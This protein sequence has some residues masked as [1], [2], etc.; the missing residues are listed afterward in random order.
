M[1]KA[2]VEAFLAEGASV[3]TCDINKEL[4]AD[5]KEN[6]ATHH[7]DR[8]LILEANLTDD[9]AQDDLFKQAIEKY[10]QVDFVVNSAG[11]MDDFAPAGEMSRALWDKV[12]AVNLTAPTM[13]TQRAVKHMQDKKIQG[14][15][16]NIAS[17]AGVRGFTAGCAYTVSKHG[18]LGLTK[19]TAAFYGPKAGI[20][21][22]AI[23]A[24]AMH[25]N[26]ASDV[27]SG[28]MKM[29]ME[30]Y[31]IMRKTCKLLLLLHKMK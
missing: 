31:G 16:V 14:S 23:M 8:T 19:N 24:G 25:T 22:N 26:I 17:I 1:G 18:L 2:I 3:V 12:I 4:I 7:P 29:D 6:V 27:I 28:K 20:R 5:F 10:G 9:A 21:C 15:I 11:V 30:G 13:I